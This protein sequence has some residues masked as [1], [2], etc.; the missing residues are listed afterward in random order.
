[1]GQIVIVVTGRP[2]QSPIIDAIATDGWQRLGPHAAERTLNVGDDAAGILTESAGQAA[3]QLIGEIRAAGLDANVVSGT[4]R[5]KR[6]LIADM[7]S[8]IIAQEMLDE[9]ADV[10]G[11]R[12]RVAE[13]TERAMRGE[14]DFEAA[15]TERVS[16][17]KNLD[18]AVL[19]ELAA[20]RVTHTAGARE[21][22]AAMK[23][24]GAHCALV[25]GGFTHFTARVAADLGFDEH[26]ANTLEIADGKL[27]GR[28]VPPILGRQA[29]RAALDDITARLG[30][31]ADD[32][33]AVGDG[34]NDLAMLE[35]AG[36]GVAF[37]AKP[38][39]RDAMASA[40]NGAILDHCD[41]TGLL[42]L[43]GLTPDRPNRA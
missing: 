43:Q 9:L 3:A 28:V 37:H 15:I 6:I 32:A 41:L 40:A 30:L 33:I 42:Y 11:M 16:L 4:N 13:I 18:A 5:R 22:V 24:V 25:S 23:A 8:T 27:T 1:M 19:G 26:R 2:D 20:T 17:L 34:A 7:E 39:L 21:L 10:I 36:I 14:L 12:D 29:K 38:G 35:A 31:T